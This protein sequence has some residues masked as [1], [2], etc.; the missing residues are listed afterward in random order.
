MQHHPFTPEYV[1][2]E[3]GDRLGRL[4]ELGE[5]EHLLLLGGD[6]V[7][8]L[9][10]AREFSAI[11]FSPRIVAEPVRRM[12]ADLLEAHPRVPQP[13]SDRA[14]PAWRSSN[15]TLSSP[16]CR[17]DRQLPTCRS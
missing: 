2:E 15:R 13:L 14:P 12:I 1:A 16:S 9:A 8:E 10:Q 11:G 4:P 7:R 5:H 6:H 3:R 17:A